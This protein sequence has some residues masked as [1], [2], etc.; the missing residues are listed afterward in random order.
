MRGRFSRCHQND[1]NCAENERYG[2]KEQTATKAA[3]GVFQ[4][5]HSGRPDKSTEIADRVNERD[6]PSGS[7]TYKEAAWERPVNRKRREKAGG[8]NGKSKDANKRCVKEAAHGDAD[9][10]GN[11]R[12]EDVVGV[13]VI[14]VRIP[15]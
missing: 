13:A 6:A 4:V 3:R 2:V 14:F 10:R 9:R 12:D 7:I 8:R 1:N 15:D 11:H 5:A